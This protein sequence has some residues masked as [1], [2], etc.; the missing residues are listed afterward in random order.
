MRHALL[1]NNMALWSVVITW[2]ISPWLSGCA[3]HQWYP[4]MPG[5]TEQAR[6]SS[7]GGSSLP[8]E[9]GFS[10][11][12]LNAVQETSQDHARRLADALTRD[13]WPA[14]HNQP[15]G[16]TPPSVQWIEWSGLPP[17]QPTQAPA[18]DHW[19][20]GQ[21][22]AD[23][24][25]RPSTSSVRHDRSKSSDASGHSWSP[26]SRSPDRQS[27]L[28]LLRDAVRHGDEPAMKKAIT[29][30]TLSF[31]DSAGVLDPVDLETL[32]PHQRRSVQRYHQLV[33]L[34]GHELISGGRA[35]DVDQV[36]DR[37]RR[38]WD[39]RP[40]RI[41]HVELCRRVRGFGVYEPFEQRVF[42]AGREQPV[43]IYAEL[44]HFRAQ[45]TNHERYQVKLSQ[46]VVLYN[47]ADGL[48]V[49]RQPKVDIL[50]ESRNRRH[51]FFVVQMIRLPARLNVGKYLLK[52]RMTDRI[53]ESLDESTIP[54]QLVAD[55]AL[56]DSGAR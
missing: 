7:P 43:I 4:P 28:T 24:H 11:H 38:L 9:E 36:V 16:A 19:Q 29:T 48:A 17:V 18:T 1:S 44:K 27:L 12:D 37:V 52:V 53:S 2:G 50:D 55:Q 51:D 45:E 8:G 41:G 3:Y 6:L 47:E 15:Q 21:P 31:A 30:A 25:D 23:D 32:E 40:V 54:I 10:T 5:A 20:A 22:D 35:L 33:T 39:R 56:V 46:E 42:L 26:P 34:L 13:T 14:D 49:W